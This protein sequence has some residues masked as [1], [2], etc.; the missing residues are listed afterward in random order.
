MPAAAYGFTKEIG[1]ALAQQDC[2]Y[3]VG[4]TL[5]GNAMAVAA[6]RATLENSLREEDFEVKLC[7]TAIQYVS[8]F[9]SSLE[10][11]LCH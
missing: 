1:A 5:T 3:S 6:V 2:E 7:F 11:Y 8:Y 9:I 4:G 10:C